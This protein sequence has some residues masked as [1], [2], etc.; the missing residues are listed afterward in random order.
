[1]YWQ[2]SWDVGYLKALKAEVIP[3]GFFLPSLFLS[4][5]LF[6]WMHKFNADFRG[7]PRHLH[8][9]PLSLHNV[10]PKFG[11]WVFPNDH[12]VGV[13][14]PQI[15]LMAS[16]LFF[17]MT[18]F[19]WRTNKEE[20][21]NLLSKLIQTNHSL[22]AKILSYINSWLKALSDSYFLKV[23]SVAFMIQNR[24]SSL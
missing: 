4:M 22:S 18:W 10:N 23:T 19:I 16:F 6:S 17:L 3:L 1:M 11:Q 12:I 15:M 8:P 7:I 2:M 24:W 5:L 20:R 14:S 21:L 13:G 9:K